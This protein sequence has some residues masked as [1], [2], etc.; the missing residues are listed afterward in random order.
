MNPSLP[1]SVTAT[2]SQRL[3]ASPNPYEVLQMRSGYSKAALDY[4]LEMCKWAHAMLSDPAWAMLALKDLCPAQVGEHVI[5]EGE[6]MGHLQGCVGVA[7]EF[8]GLQLCVKLGPNKEVR[9]AAKNATPLPTPPTP[10]T[11]Q[12]PSAGDYDACIA[13]AAQVASILRREVGSGKEA[14]AYLSVLC[15][16][17]RIP[18]ALRKSASHVGG[19]PVREGEVGFKDM[20]ACRDPGNAVYAR[21]VDLLLEKAVAVASPLDVLR[22]MAPE[23]RGDVLEAL[24]GAAA[25]DLELRCDRV[26]RWRYLVGGSSH[27][28]FY[29]AVQEVLRAIEDSER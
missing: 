22:W 23:K 21:A 7:G 2:M 14:L 17:W 8:D 29:P 1:V 25:V 5:L 27:P 3:A 4:R 9:V 12:Q 24:L 16:S 10:P 6:E 15:D 11:P 19:I 18:T 20:P 26:P 28:D 13:A